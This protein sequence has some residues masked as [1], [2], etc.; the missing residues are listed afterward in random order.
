MILPSKHL[1]QDRALLTV[2]AHVLQSLSNPKTVS[3]VWDDL[4]RSDE[5][6]RGLIPRLQYDQFILAL[7]VLFLINAIEV[8]EGLLR[9]KVS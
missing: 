7:D 1:P 4:T 3:A 2:G 5:E 8:A 9:R 6:T